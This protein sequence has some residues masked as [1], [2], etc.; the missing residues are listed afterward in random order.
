MKEVILIHGLHA[1]NLSTYIARNLVIAEPVP[2]NLNL[3]SSV[4]FFAFDR[5]DTDF[6]TNPDDIFKIV[7]SEAQTDIFN[8]LKILSIEIIDCGHLLIILP[9]V[10]NYV[11]PEVLLAYLKYYHSNLYFIITS[12]KKLVHKEIHNYIDIKKD[13]GLVQMRLTTR[14]QELKYL[15][16]LSFNSGNFEFL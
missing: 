9:N 4:A 8:F 5:Y 13:N 6:H 7:I 12:D 11:A 14:K 15:S 16:K 1:A 2:F 3:P 10:F